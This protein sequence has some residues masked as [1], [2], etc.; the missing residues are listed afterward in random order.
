MTPDPRDIQCP[1]CGADAGDHCVTASGRSFSHKVHRARIS[2]VGLEPPK[3]GQP[4]RQAAGIDNLP[5]IVECPLCIGTM[6]RSDG[7]KRAG[8]ECSDGCGVRMEVTT[9]RRWA[10]WCEQSGEGQ[11]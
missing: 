11:L 3:W 9:P 2:A 4:R 6:V 7:S 8:F 5:E 10:R 1:D